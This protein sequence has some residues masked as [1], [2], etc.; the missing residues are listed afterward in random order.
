M[1]DL[2]ESSLALACM[3]DA[4]FC[5]DVE[6]GAALTITQVARAI[7]E[8]LR[9]H[10]DWNGLTRAVRTAFANEPAEAACREEWCRRVAERALN[11][12]DIALD[13]GD[14]LV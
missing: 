5:S 3:T 1:F 4:L 9:V 13:C 7:S 11:W 8:A 10:R 14:S 2:D 12:A 6:S